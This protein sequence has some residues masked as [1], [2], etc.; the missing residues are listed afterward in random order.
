MDVIE[1]TISG[2][3]LFKGNKLEDDRGDFLKIFQ[4]PIFTSLGLETSFVE[5]YITT[6]NKGVIRGMHFQAPP[7]DHS[8]LVCCISGKIKDGLVDLRLNSKTFGQSLSLI[9]DS[10]N[11]EIL[12]IPKGIA[13]GF[14]AYQNNSKLI[15]MV[16]SLYNSEFDM[17]IHYDSVG[18]NWWHEGNFNHHTNAVV[19]SRDENFPY[20]SEFK[21]PFVAL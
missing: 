20:L 12:Y 17:G 16:T 21:S 15:Y 3:Y 18:I 14:A 11:N 4:A 7:F 19:S 9:L 5:S 2:C 13:H 10:K 6:S 8:K 1:L